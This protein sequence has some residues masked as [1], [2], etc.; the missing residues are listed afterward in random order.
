MQMGGGWGGSLNRGGGS[1]N[2]KVFCDCTHPSS[3][4][5]IR[6]EKTSLMHY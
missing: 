2:F 5:H 3:V 6:N 4:R 1:M